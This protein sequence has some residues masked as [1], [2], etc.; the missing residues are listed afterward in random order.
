MRLATFHVISV[1]GSVIGQ[2]ILLGS[3]FGDNSCMVSSQRF[4]MRVGASSVF[5]GGEV[6]RIDL[7]GC[8][9]TLCSA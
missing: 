4:M 5:K 1:T 3:W 7:A 9:A 8:S 2:T 6:V